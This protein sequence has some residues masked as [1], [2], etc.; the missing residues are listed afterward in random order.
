MSSKENADIR[1]MLSGKLGNEAQFVSRFIHYDL[2]NLQEI[3]D[4]R[5]YDD[6]YIKFLQISVEYLNG[7]QSPSPNMTPSA[8]VKKTNNKNFDRLV[9]KW[10]TPM[11]Q[12]TNFS[13]KN[14]H[15]PEV[16]NGS[17]ASDTSTSKKRT[18]PSADISILNDDDADFKEES[19][20][21]IKTELFKST[22]KKKLKKNNVK[23][24]VDKDVDTISAESESN[25]PTKNPS[26]KMKLNENS[27]SPNKKVK[28]SK[29]TGEDD[30]ATVTKTKSKK[31]KGSKKKKGSK[32]KNVEEDHNAT[33]LDA[34]PKYDDDQEIVVKKSKKTK[35]TK[36][37]K[38]KDAE[39]GASEETK[40]AKTPA[41]TE[42]KMKAFAKTPLTNKRLSR[43]ILQS[44][45]KN[46]TNK[47][48]RPVTRRAAAEAALNAKKL[49]KTNSSASSKSIKP[50][51][52]TVQR[53]KNSETAQKSPVKNLIGKFEKL[54][55]T[56]F[57]K[58]KLS[59]ELGDTINR[60]K[61]KN[62]IDERKLRT[63]QAKLEA[64]RKSVKK[65][66]QFLQQN[67][68]KRA[69][70]TI[71]DQTK[72]LESD[73]NC[74]LD[75]TIDNINDAPSNK[76]IT[77]KALKTPLKVSISSGAANSTNTFINCNTAKDQ[78]LI[79][80]ILKSGSPK[81]QVLHTKIPVSGRISSASAFLAEQQRRLT[82]EFAGQPPK[83]VLPLNPLAKMTPSKPS[84]YQFNNVGLSALKPKN[85]IPKF[86][87]PSKI[88][89]NEIDEKRKAELLLKE[90]NEKK[91]LQEQERLK[92][93]KRDESKKK[94]EEKL[95]KIQEVKQ[96]KE[97]ELEQK[98]KEMEE[99]MTHPASKLTSSTSNQSI[100]QKSIFLNSTQNHVNKKIFGQNESSK[101]TNA[102]VTINKKLSTVD[103]EELSNF[104]NNFGKFKQIQALNTETEEISKPSTNKFKDAEYETNSLSKLMHNH[105]Q[106]LESTYVLPKPPNLINK[107][108]QNKPEILNT[109]TG[110]ASYEVTPLQ[111]PKLKDAN[112]YDVSNL[113]SDDDTDDDEE[114]K[115]PIPNWAIQANLIKKVKEQN[116]AVI[117]FTR[118]FKSA[119]KSEIILEEIFKTRRKKFTERSSSANWN[120]PPLWQSNGLTGEESFRVH[121]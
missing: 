26:K 37:S 59:G 22:K 88:N 57:S 75:E 116:N 25:D 9:E 74:A 32:H 73:E 87:T 105:Q 29:K 16:S 110:P 13:V 108:L 69:S 97:L 121:R 3:T 43:I 111:A 36:A 79:D 38:A 4:P 14:I 86:C 77:D 118:L 115:K 49:T 120:C 30:E 63:S 56:P 82:K 95:K 53:I 2:N 44:A 92:Q 12:R 7:L 60:I 62:P 70:N 100:H 47:S 33:D 102:K 48:R 18:A 113:G 91:R 72:N 106:N 17:E 109:N 76:S 31:T 5:P 112:N 101:N 61:T 99:K 85:A 45:I 10:R 11:T 93:E 6:I 50:V 58:K 90:Q 68:S 104:A 96:K 23:S 94:R 55:K 89:R 28:K 40:S 54:N 39:V 66:Q 84:N 21:E 71:C 46:S 117:N 27:E 98:R 65:A 51:N 114:P 80:K 81:C 20:L 35:K 67:M 52:P 83:I 78:E 119:S 15:V 1:A 24:S 103:K 19:D 64:K 41:R 8:G 42:S 107:P 34:D